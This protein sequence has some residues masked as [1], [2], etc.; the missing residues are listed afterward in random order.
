MINRDGRESAVFYV[1]TQMF[2]KVTE[3]F[4]IKVLRRMVYF[5]LK[6]ENITEGLGKISSRVES[7]SVLFSN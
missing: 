5:D 6:E 1:Y 3:D 2:S 4:E 7:L